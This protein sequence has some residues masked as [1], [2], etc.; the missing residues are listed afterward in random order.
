MRKLIIKKLKEMSEDYNEQ[1]TLCTLQNEAVEYY[2]GESY[3]YSMDDFM[4]VIVS[5]EDAENV[6]NWVFY[7]DF[8]PNHDWACLNGYAN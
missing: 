5:G 2:N 6:I 4:E 8:N 7:G 3:I 1:S